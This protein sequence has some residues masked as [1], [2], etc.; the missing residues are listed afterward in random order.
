MVRIFFKKTLC[1]FVCFTASIISGCGLK[2]IQAFENAKNIEK[3]RLINV[4]YEQAWD[5]AKSFIP[6]IINYRFPEPEKL[7]SI[8]K[9]SGIIEIKD[10]DYSGKYLTSSTNK[11]ITAC[12]FAGFPKKDIK[13]KLTASGNKTEVNVDVTVYAQKGKIHYSGGGYY[14]VPNG[15]GGYSIEQDPVKETQDESDFCVSTGEIEKLVLDS[16]P[17]NLSSRSPVKYDSENRFG[18]LNDELGNFNALVIDTKT[19]LIWKRCVEGQTW[20]GSSC[21]GS[22]KEFSFQEAI[23]YASSQ[24]N[25]HLPTLEE[26]QTI[27]DGMLKADPGLKRIVFP[28]AP[29]G[30]FWTSSQSEKY[31]NYMK[32]VFYGTGAI[33]ENNK[34]VKNAV[35][36]VR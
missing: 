7:L 19:G 25:W 34:D 32:I 35:R 14:A 3:S 4:N 11:N 13:I 28:D 26:L 9:D 1:F 5:H 15:F 24:K 33:L 18:Y 36:L 23:N 8:N 12:K 21:A 31:S 20:N 6:K 30:A 16:F 22:E 2:K 27:S 17:N 10:F 29:T